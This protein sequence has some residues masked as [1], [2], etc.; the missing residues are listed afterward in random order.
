[1][2]NRILDISQPDDLYLKQTLKINSSSMTKQVVK[3]KNIMVFG[4][5]LADI[6]PEKTILGGAPFNVARHLHAFQQHAILVSR[7]GND[8]LGSELLVQMHELGMDEI[9]IQSDSNF[10]TGQVVVN[11]EGKSH[12]FDILPDQAYDHIHSGLTHFV[13]LSVHPDMVY[14]GTLAQRGIE[15]RLA[16]DTF[17][18][19]AKS[20]KF[21]DLNLRSPWFDKHIIRRSLLRADIVKLND[22]E[23]DKITSLFNLLGRNRLENGRY[24]VKKFELKYLF[25]TCGKDGAWLL[26]KEGEETNIEGLD[27]GERLVN[28]IGGGDAFSS[29]CILGLLSGWS[30]SLILERANQFAAAICLEQGATPEHASFYDAFVSEWGLH[31]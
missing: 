26:N 9:G 17:L 4:E 3:K 11:M 15:S 28:T 7:A 30:E 14:F 24:L 20:P 25:V 31:A 29:V 19:D 13:T 8:Q 23:L 2:G 1:M 16:L 22:I 21:L 27:L 12:S 10:P 18:S 5:V 6:F